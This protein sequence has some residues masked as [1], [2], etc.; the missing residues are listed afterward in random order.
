MTV[1][2]IVKALAGEEDINFGD[3]D[4]TFSRQTR[5]GGT[6]SIHYI[7]SK[8][9]PANTLGGVVD[10]HLHT[11]NTDTGTT[12][13]T[14]EVNSDGFGVTL[15]STGLSADRTYTFPNTWSSQPLVGY[16]DL[17]GTGSGATTGA[18]TVGVYDV[19]G[20]FTGGTVEAVLAEL[21]TDVAA[22]LLPYGYKRGFT[23]GYVSTSVISLTQ[24]QWHHSGTT[25]QMVYSAGAFNYTLSSL[26]GTQLQY[27][28]LDDS[29]IV[30]AGTAVITLTQ[31]TNSTTAP[32]FSNTKYGWYNGEDRCIGAVYVEGGLA[33]KFR[34]FSDNYYG[35]YEAHILF[36]S[37][38]SPTSDTS[39]D[40]SA[41]V[42]AFSTGCR[43]AIQHATTGDQISFK[44]TTG[45]AAKTQV[46]VA[47]A[48]EYQDARVDLDTDQTALW[49]TDTDS[50]TIIG[51][52][53]YY[54]GDL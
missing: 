14:F 24:G 12:E 16:T 29:A 2:Q 40:F 34:L 8:S 23:L 1:L 3:S 35:F 17:I 18:K 27:I 43:I 50:Q 31:I 47:D 22:Y 42:P 46:T 20:N 39:L 38:N 51:L 26:S 54:T 13:D 45:W 10:T 15:S 28:Y 53:G 11:Q 32:T 52:H 19:A 6:T 4:T 9:I 33:R 49:A 25:E 36:T 5:S 41:F 30:S 44:P 21:A 37:A 48:A 7:D